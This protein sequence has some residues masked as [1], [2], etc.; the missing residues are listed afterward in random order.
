[1]S[2]VVYEDKFYN[3][4]IKQLFISG[5]GKGTQKI[6]NRMF[7]VSQQMESDL[8][9]DLYDFTRDQIR[10]LLF[11]YAPSTE[12]SSRANATWVS[13]YIDWAIEKGYGTGLNPLNGITTEWK[14]QF[15]V[16]INK[17]FWTYNEIKKILDKRANFQDGC[18]VALLFNGIRGN[19]NSEITNLKASDIDTDNNTL[20]VKD[21]DG[22]VRTV[23]VDDECIK[24]CVGAVRESVYEK[25]NGTPS[26]D[27]KAPTTN[28]IN[29]EF[30]VRASNTRTIHVDEAE[31]NIVHRR[32]A[33]IADE[34]GEPNFTPMN[35]VN[36]G[37]LYLAKEL[38]K[39]TGRLDQEEYEMIFDKFNERSEQS[40][41]R[42]KNEFLNLETIK[43]V[44][45]TL[46]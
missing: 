34:I 38:Y 28:L 16:N 22:S 35:L 27:T 46:D 24:Q 25:M 43:E 33:K 42:I 1:M 31:K 41:Y 13:R 21:E 20:T 19:S 2:N 10:K 3:E 5:Y 37:M 29:N 9:K 6:L 39:T 8:K 12:Y 11:L 18:I 45:S 14:N 30:V 15:V 32:L 4:E 36:S 17:R 7:K 40:K 44:Y 26:I 23:S